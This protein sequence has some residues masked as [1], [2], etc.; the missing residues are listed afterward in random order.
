MSINFDCVHS[1]IK[2]DKDIIFSGT[3]SNGNNET[4]Y[5]EYNIYGITITFSVRKKNI[6]A[7][8][9]QC[10]KYCNIIDDGDFYTTLN[11]SAKKIKILLDNID[12]CIIKNKL[13]G[14]KFEK[15]ECFKKK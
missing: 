1:L 5:Y 3:S 8:N 7:S 6:E 12:K 2:E 15:E 13:N 9:N 10:Q 14:C 4:E 11:T